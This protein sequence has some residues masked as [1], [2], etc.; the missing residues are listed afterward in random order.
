HQ[1]ALQRALAR[2]ITVRVH[3]E[4]DYNTAVKASQILFGKSTTEDLS[5]LDEKTLLA[6]FEG[7]PQVDINRSSLDTVNVTDFLS[8]TTQGVV[9]SSKGEARRMIQGGGVSINKSKIIDSEQTLDFQ[10][11]QDK[12]LLVQKGKKNYYLVRAI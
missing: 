6:V 11:L 5:S 3:S 9:F 8:E 2:D 12:Y 7:V 1:R 10:L 4:A